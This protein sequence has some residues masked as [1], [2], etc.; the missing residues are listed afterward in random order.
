VRRIGSMRSRR[1]DGRI[2]ACT[3]RNL[4]TELEAGAL[5]HLKD[6]R[7]RS[8]YKRQNLPSGPFQYS[9]AKHWR[10]FTIGRDPAASMSCAT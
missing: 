10:R 6:S 8:L 2:I 4:G 9:P 1:V 5:A 3:N 7:G